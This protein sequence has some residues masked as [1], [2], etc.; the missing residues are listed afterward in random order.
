MAEAKSGDGIMGNFG[1]VAV[2]KTSV[3]VRGDRLGICHLGVIQTVAFRASHCAY[4]CLC[5]SIE[6]PNL[7]L[8][9]R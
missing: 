2:G 9:Y 3:R 1:A 4:L 7:A 6:V 8:A 5:I